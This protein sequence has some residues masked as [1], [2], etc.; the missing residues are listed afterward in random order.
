MTEAAPISGPRRLAREAALQILY[1][2]DMCEGQASDLSEK[3]WSEEPLA[4]KTKAF[5]ER[6]VAGVGEH[7]P[8]IDDVIRKYAQNWEMGRMATIDRCILRMAAFE[9]IHELETPV[10]VVINE[11]VEIAKKYSTAESS[12]FVNG[13]LDKVKEERPASPAS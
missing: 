4:P 9:L 7:Q 2:V 8:Q 6:I 11:A 12:K 1:L 10:S 3:T 5:A 13:I